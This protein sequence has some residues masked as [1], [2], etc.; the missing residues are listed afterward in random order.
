MKRTSLI[1]DKVSF[2]RIQKIISCRHTHFGSVDLPLKHAESDDAIVGT[3]LAE[4][5]M[6]LFQMRFF[7]RKDCV[8]F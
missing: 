1:N 8:H 7:V 4:K 3:K 5:V 2:C 6:D